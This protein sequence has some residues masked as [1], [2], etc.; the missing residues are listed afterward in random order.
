VVVAQGS[1]AG[2]H[3][4]ANSASIISL[5]PEII[6]NLPGT[7]VIAAGGISDATGVVAALA[8]GAEGVVMGTRFAVCAESAM[9]DKAK[10]VIIQT[11]DG[12]ASTKRF[13]LVLIQKSD[14]RTRIF[15]ELRGKD[16]LRT[17]DGRAIIN[18]TLQDFENGVSGTELKEKFD[19]AMK[20]GD[21]SRL[22]VF[23]GTGSGLVTKRQTVA[24]I[25]TEVETQVVERVKSVNEAL[26]T[27]VDAIVKE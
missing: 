3:G 5:V 13:V 4:T 10:A 22:V 17:H 9:P 25:L 8:L 23:A 19:V 14:F 1:D 7:P 24:E 15:D 12:G 6:S 26:A 20:E 27:A 11:Q 2:G 16:W 21:F 18:D